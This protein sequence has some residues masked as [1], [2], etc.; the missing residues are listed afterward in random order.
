M[1]VRTYINLDLTIDLLTLLSQ[2]MAQTLA[3][4][5][6]FAMYCFEVLSELNLDLEKLSQQSEAFKQVFSQGLNDGDNNVRVASLKATTAFLSSIEDQTV[7]LK[8]VDIL[9]L[10]LR[11]V[12]EALKTDED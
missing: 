3:K 10:I 11:I 6:Q 5:R 1:L 7:V 12:I 4:L 8:F 9:D 2:L